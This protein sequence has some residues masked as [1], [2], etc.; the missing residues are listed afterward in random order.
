M[1]T[2]RLTITSAPFLCSVPSEET[3]LCLIL[4]ACERFGYRL[5]GSETLFPGLKFLYAS[6]TNATDKGRN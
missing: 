4:L 6:A 3:F 5:I 2:E 1:E